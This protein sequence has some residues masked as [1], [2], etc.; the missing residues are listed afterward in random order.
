MPPRPASG[1]GPDPGGV[2]VRGAA[3]EARAPSMP[4]LDSTRLLGYGPTLEA[5]RVRR[6]PAGTW[7]QSAQASLRR[8][9]GPRPGNRALHRWVAHVRGTVAVVPAET[10]MVASDRRPGIGRNIKRRLRRRRQGAA[11]PLESAPAAGGGCADRLR[12]ACGM[13]IVNRSTGLWSLMT[14][15]LVVA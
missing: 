10:M 7:T 2:R 4:V 13:S 15:S 5:H 11:R 6:G 9:L 1:A 12:S 8:D 14:S 3:G